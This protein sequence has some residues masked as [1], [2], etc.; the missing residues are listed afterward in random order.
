M[1][2]WMLRLGKVRD[3]VSQRSR[4]RKVSSLLHA[5]VDASTLK[6]VF[7]LVGNQLAA[8]NAVASDLRG[9]LK[10]LMGVGVVQTTSMTVRWL[11]TL[12]WML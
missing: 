11:S 9:S 6:S 5:F 8:D 2:S 12:S 1:I 7:S 3:C 4:C 10:L